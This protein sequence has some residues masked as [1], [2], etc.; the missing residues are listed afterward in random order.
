M[1]D[2]L[3]V[4]RVGHRLILIVLELNVSQ[5]HIRNILHVYPTDAKLTFPL[6]LGPD[7]TVALIV[8]RGDHLRH[9]AKMTGSVYREEQIKG[10]TFATRFSIRLIQPFITVLRAAPN[11]ILDGS[12]DIVLRVGFDHEKPRARCGLIKVHGIVV[13]LHF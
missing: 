12:V 4:S 6:V 3:C 5:L 8:N 10:C 2:L 13:V 11:F 7:T 9:T 1:W